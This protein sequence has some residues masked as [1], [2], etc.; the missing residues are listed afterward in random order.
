MLAEGARTAEEMVW[1]QQAAH[2]HAMAHSAWQLL[3]ICHTPVRA[4][5]NPTASAS[6]ML[7]PLLLHCME[8][9]CAVLT[10][11]AS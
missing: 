3:Y 8:L 4:A 11:T 6:I 9:G 10:C 5:L 7:I 1:R 2:I